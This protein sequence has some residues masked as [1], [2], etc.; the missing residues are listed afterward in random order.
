MKED[1]QNPSDGA[2]VRQW[3][4]GDEEAFNMLYDRYRLPLYSY[5]NRLVTGQPALVDELYQQTWIRVLDKLPNYR[6]RSAFVSWLFRI[7]HN[8]AVDHFRRTARLKPVTDEQRLPEQAPDPQRK[9][10]REQLYDEV[11]R[12]VRELPPEQAEV[13]MLRQNGLS[14]K[15]IARIQECSLN[16]A[17]GRMHYAVRRLRKMMLPEE[18]S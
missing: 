11:E 3:R 4:N 8:L 16:T 1:R 13:V 17:L 7:A 15:E 9:V 10:E 6:D 14:F 2:L 18:V 12:C 5:L